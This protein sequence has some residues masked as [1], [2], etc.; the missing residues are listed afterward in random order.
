MAC[1]LA[2]KPFFSPCIHVRIFALLM[3]AAAVV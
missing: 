3:S 1:R 2:L